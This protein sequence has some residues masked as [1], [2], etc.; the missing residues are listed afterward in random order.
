ML[1]EKTD[2]F[3]FVVDNALHKSIPSLSVVLNCLEHDITIA[4][5]LFKVNLLK[6]NP[7]KFQFMLLSR[8]KVFSISAKLRTATFFLEI[9]YSF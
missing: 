2:I 6:A 1:I 5:K 4:L 3:N 7:H 8:K 9:K